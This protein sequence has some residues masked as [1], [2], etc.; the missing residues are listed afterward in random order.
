MLAWGSKHVCIINS[1]RQHPDDWASI[2]YDVFIQ[3]Y[4]SYS[5]VSNQRV[6]AALLSEKKNLF[7][8]RL[9]TSI[10]LYDVFSNICRNSLV[11]AYA[12]VKSATQGIKV[13][14]KD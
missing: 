12:K 2:V 13:V 8:R 5:D 1:L 9:H 6:Y 7:F 4:T 10:H 11:V 3:L 14:V